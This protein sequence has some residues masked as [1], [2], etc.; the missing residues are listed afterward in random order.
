[1]KK[2]KKVAVDSGRVLA[3]RIESKGRDEFPAAEEQRNK[4]QDP[5]IS[6]A[7]QRKGR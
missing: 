2:K 4:T 1:M 7:N 3:M 6:G 5:G